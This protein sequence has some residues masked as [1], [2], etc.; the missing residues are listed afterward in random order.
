VLVRDVANYWTLIAGPAQEHVTR[1]QERSW[2]HA[3]HSVNRAC[4]V[5]STSTISR[6]IA[7]QSYCRAIRQYGPRGLVIELL[8]QLI[9]QK[10]KSNET[11]NTEPNCEPK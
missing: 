3:A 5:M 1:F 2:G 10:R 6:H 9:P 8:E 7:V 11:G 4:C